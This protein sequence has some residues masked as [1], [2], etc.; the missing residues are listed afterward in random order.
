MNILFQK[1]NA[2]WAKYSEYEYKKGEDGNLYIM[3]APKA[4]PTTYDPLEDAETLVIDALNVGRLAMK[5]GSEKELQQA[6]L[7]F[8]TRYGLLGFMTALPTTPEFMNYDAV[9]LPKNHFIKDETMSLQEYLPL[10][11]PFEKPDLYRI[12]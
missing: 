9:Y 7:E 5:R 6:L 4:T 10:F 12:T 2:C 11:S 1:T 8:V 3:P